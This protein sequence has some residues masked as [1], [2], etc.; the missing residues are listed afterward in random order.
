[1][2]IGELISMGG[3]SYETGFNTLARISGN[4]ADILL[5]WLLKAWRKQW[6]SLSEAE[7][8]KGQG[9]REGVILE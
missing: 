8:K 7:K 4:G 9:L 1:M 2:D 6:P 3:L 5:V